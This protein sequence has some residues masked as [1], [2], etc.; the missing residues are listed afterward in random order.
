MTILSNFKDSIIKINNS[1]NLSESPI[2]N[3]A[4]DDEDQVTGLKLSN[5]LIQRNISELLD[6]LQEF[7]KQRKENSIIEMSIKEIAEE[8][9]IK[10]LQQLNKDI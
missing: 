10:D 4:S 8:H 3:E 1:L 7:G 2:S 5:Y 9:G 6:M